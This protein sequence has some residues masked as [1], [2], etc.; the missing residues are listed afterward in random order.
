M[1]RKR[2]ILL[3]TSDINYDQRLQKVSNSL[4]NFGAEVLL[5]GRKLPRALG[6]EERAF[7]QKRVTCIFNTGILFYLEINIRFFLL[8][9]KERSNIVCANDPDT[10]MAAI[11][12]SYFKSFELIYDSH[13]YFTEVPELKAHG[14]KKKIWAFV[15]Q[16]GIQKSTKCYTVNQSI[17]LL[18][19]EK[20]D[21]K[22]EVIMNVPETF[23]F[24]LLEI[25][26]NIIFYQGA[27]NEGRGLPELIQ[28]MKY[29][30]AKLLLAGDG[31][32]KDV[33]LTQVEKAGLGN[34][35]NFLGKVLPKDLR[36]LT[37]QAK[38]GV[39]LLE[40][41]SQSYFYSLANKFFD[42]MHFGVPSINMPFPEYARINALH[43]VAVLVPTLE[44]QEIVT[45]AN[46][47]LNDQ[48]KYETLSKNCREAKNFYNWEIEEAKLKLIYGL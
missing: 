39:N 27:L 47:L 21:K 11:L 5:I 3:A 31:D 29:I 13:E 8:L 30:E 22:F 48:E 34:K 35:V 14:F 25:K 2:I 23:S 43:E 38:I 16:W 18:L 45:A 12:A 9:L 41:K 6:L 10:F 42:Y 33:L 36:A 4:A 17:A 40:Q 15:E 46:K 28:A 24:E 1:E 7:Q 37:H 44:V 32:L 19:K 26:E 20:Y